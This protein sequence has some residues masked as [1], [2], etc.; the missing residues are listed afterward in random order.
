MPQGNQAKM[1]I[2]KILRM[3]IK[4]LIQQLKKIPMPPNAIIKIEEFRTVKGSN[5]FSISTLGNQLATM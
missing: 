3:F 5:P 2:H 4:E 1:F